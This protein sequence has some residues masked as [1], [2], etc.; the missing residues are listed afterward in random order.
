MRF[1]SVLPDNWSAGWLATQYLFD[2][3]HRD[4]LY[5]GSPNRFSLKRRMEG[6]RIALDE[7]GIA[8][9]K[10]V[11]MIDLHEMGIDEEMAQPAIYKAIEAGR[12]KNATGIF[13]NTDVLALG[14]MQ[15]LEA[16]GYNIPHDYSVISLDDIPIARHSRPPLTTIQIDRAELGRIGAELLLERISSP[17]SNVRRVNLGVKLIERASVTKPRK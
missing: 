15:A 17:E 9:D 10:S 7:A 5:I 16:H 3:G 4:I 11:H 6:F 8:F 13:C 12:F 1:S 14:V 2:A